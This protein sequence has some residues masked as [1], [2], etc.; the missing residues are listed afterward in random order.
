MGPEQAV[1]DRDLLA[2]AQHGDMSAFEALV[3]RHRDGVFG[4]ALRMLRSEADAAEVTQETFLSAYQNL[5]TFRAEAAFGS[6]VHRIA[7]NHA[8]MRLRHR[9]VVESAEGE[10]TQPQFNARGSWEDYP[11]SDWSRR[12]DEKAMDA[13]LRR[14]I[15][16]ATDRLPEGYREVFLLKD[17]EG[18]SYEQIAEMTGDSVAAIKSRLHRARLALREAIDRFYNPS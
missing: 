5:K 1:L 11:A 9:R 16:Q 3:E 17:V 6:W 7:A 13:E 15:E 18:L 8:L 10:L 4:L 12:A 2:R 14:A